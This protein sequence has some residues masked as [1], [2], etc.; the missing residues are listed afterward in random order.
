MDDSNTRAGNTNNEVQCVE[1][2]V[3]KSSLQRSGNNLQWTLSVYSLE[4]QPFEIHLP[5]EKGEKFHFMVYDWKRTIKHLLDDLKIPYA[6]TRYF[7]T[8]TIY[9]EPD[10]RI[11]FSE[12][13]ARILSRWNTVPV[14]SKVNDHVKSLS[15]GSQD[16]PAEFGE[17]VFD[18]TMIPATH[19]N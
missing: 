13:D 1:I 5:E 4:N 3:T 8:D 18:E 16:I 10:Q 11:I 9:P 19:R 7:F 12:E 14:D 15:K 17:F 6:I 2:V